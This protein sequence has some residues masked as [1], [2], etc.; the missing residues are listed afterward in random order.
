MQE[1]HTA[2][3]HVARALR[4][5]V[6]RLCLP[7]HPGSICNG[8]AATTK[9]VFLQSYTKAMIGCRTHACSG[10]QDQGMHERPSN[11]PRW[12]MEH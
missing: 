3:A 12:N 2:K 5:R 4:A 9:R 7:S 10:D 6:W 1:L 8:L 11:R